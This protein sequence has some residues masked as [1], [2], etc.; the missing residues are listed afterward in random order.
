[1]ETTTGT[2]PKRAGLGLTPA[3]GGA[4]VPL[5]NAVV[6]GASAYRVPA[7]GVAGCTGVPGG[8]LIHR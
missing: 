7:I 2:V 1:M 4:G 6:R 8:Y 3:P 5:E